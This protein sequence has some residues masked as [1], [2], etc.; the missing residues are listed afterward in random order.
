MA[1]G[2]GTFDSSGSIYSTQYGDL[3]AS[4]KITQ[5]I[6]TTNR[7]VK[8]T[9]WGMKSYYR[10]PGSPLWDITTGELVDNRYGSLYV[11]IGSD[12]GVEHSNE[13]HG[14]VAKTNF[15]ANPGNVYRQSDG[16]LRN[17]DNNYPAEWTAT[18][19]YYYNASGSAISDTFAVEVSVGDTKVSVSG[20]FTTDPIT[21]GPTGL[22]LSNVTT[23]D[24]TVTGTV[25]ISSWGT[26]TGTKKK[27][28]SVCAA[29]GDVNNRRYSEDFS[30]TLS[31]TLT[32]TNSSS[33]IGSLT[34]RPNTKY[35]VTMF[36]INGTV[37]VGNTNYTEVITKPYAPTA[38][39]TSI[40]KDTAVLTIAAPSGQG[41]ASTMTAYYKINGGAAVSAGTVASAGS[42]VK[43]LTGLSPNTTYTLTIYISNSSGASTSIT[44]TFTTK[45]AMY[46]SISGK[47]K[48]IKKMYG[49]V[50]GKTRLIKHLYGSVNGKTKKIF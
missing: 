8:I 34:I 45:V 36:A 2:F 28:F 35:W 46:G 7:T 24:S 49:S 50:N 17:S 23:T 48:A 32:T 13:C 26:A 4:A 5:E 25:S 15:R 30:S 21:T 10:K 6:N 44:R 38:S 16:Y 18:R 31:S 11:R 43:T 12:R 27:S 39:V 22:T 14:V 40:T 20:T 47:T 42:V 1:S 33:V 29:S 41:A 3:K 9:L 37:G 19:T